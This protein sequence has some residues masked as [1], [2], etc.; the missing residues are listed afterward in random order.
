[1]TC[2]KCN[3]EEKEDSPIRR[4]V[5]QATI[6]EIDRTHMYLQALAEKQLDRSQILT[7]G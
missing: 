2:T 1:M 5:Q 3:T 4:L 6:R 7:V